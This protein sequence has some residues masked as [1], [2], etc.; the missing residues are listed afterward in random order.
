MPIENTLSLLDSL[1]HAVEPDSEQWRI[2]LIE[3][4]RSMSA[5]KWLKVV[6]RFEDNLPASLMV[7]PSGH[8]G[9]TIGSAAR[10][11]QKAAPVD[12]IEIPVTQAA[13][14]A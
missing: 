13:G 12:R 7:V 11:L 8:R 6:R 3:M 1:L 10:A 2:L 9:H 14:T 5:E 4:H